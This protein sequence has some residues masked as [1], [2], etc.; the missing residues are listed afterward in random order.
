MKQFGPLARR[1][2]AKQRRTYKE[3]QVEKRMVTVAYTD[4][5]NTEV[6]AFDPKRDTPETVRFLTGRMRDNGWVPVK[7][8]GREVV[9]VDG[10]VTDYV[11]PVKM[12]PVWKVA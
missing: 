4:G 1:L 2:A 3:D 9:I 6:L 7:G 11:A 10:V 8:S 12:R 5:R